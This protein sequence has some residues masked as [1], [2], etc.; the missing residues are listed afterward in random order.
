MDGKLSIPFATSPEP[1]L[2]KLLRSKNSRSRRGSSENLKIS[3]RDQD[4]EETIL[5]LIIKIV[6]GTAVLLT[7]FFV[8]TLGLSEIAGEGGKTKA[9]RLWIVVDGLS[10][11]IEHRGSSSFWIKEIGRE[12]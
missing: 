11:W 7:T 8:S 5:R 6:L 4:S 9:V 2:S 1:L 10:S 3:R 12:S